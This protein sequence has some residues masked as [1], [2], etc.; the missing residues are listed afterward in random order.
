MK[1]HTQDEERAAFKRLLAKSPSTDAYVIRAAKEGDLK[2][3]IK[4]LRTETRVQIEVRQ[5]LAD[6]LEGKFRRKRGRQPLATTEARHLHVAAMVDELRQVQG[7]K[8]YIAIEQIATQLGYSERT[9][10]QPLAE[11]KAFMERVEA[12]FNKTDRKLSDLD[13]LFEVLGAW[14]D[15]GK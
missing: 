7:D 11:K 2:P 15:E 5:F 8:Q 1:R 12:A 10:K 6:Y 3:L 13:F 4:I 14:P 9:V